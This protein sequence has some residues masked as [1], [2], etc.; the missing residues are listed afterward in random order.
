MR[1]A[2]T[3]RSSI[4]RAL[5]FSLFAGWSGIVLA[6]GPP[7]PIER[8]APPAA[9]VEQ[10]QRH[11]VGPDGRRG[12]EHLP[13]WME[14]H[15]GMTLEQQQ[16]A[17]DREPGFR[18]LPMQTQMQM[19]QRL[20]QLNAM[21]PEMRARTLAH[22]EAMERLSPAQRSQV[23]GVMQQLGSLPQDQRRQVIRAFRD[24]RLMPPEVR[25]GMVNSPRYAWLSYQQRTVLINL[26][27]IAP[28]LPVD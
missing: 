15:R 4:V 26:I 23:R 14:Q 24:L 6:Q 25:M 11:L 18:E 3:S 19:H 28:I 27:V 1:K 21:T 12:G 16:E 20:A 5:V 7:A 2:V 17:L 9:G 13:E 8:Q 22:T 10:G